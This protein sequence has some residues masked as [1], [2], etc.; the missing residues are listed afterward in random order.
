[1]G[2]K[3][4]DESDKADAQTARV[5]RRAV[6]CNFC[7]HWYIHPCTKATQARCP[8][9]IAKRGRSRTPQKS[10]RHHYIP[11]FY[12][13][14]WC[15]EDKR[16]RQFSRPHKPIYAKRIFPVQTGFVDRLYEVKGVP[17]EMAQVVEDEF[18][19][20]PVPKTPS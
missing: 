10:I 5:G 16:L 13:K 12:L 8:N 20:H 7:K 2:G 11:V 4:P 14:R 9:T 3:T 17:A 15:A 19:L 6:L 18:G 1:V